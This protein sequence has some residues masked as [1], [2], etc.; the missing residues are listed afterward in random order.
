MFRLCGREQGVRLAV[1]MAAVCSFACDGPAPT[2]V[3]AATFSAASGHTALVERGRQ[4]FFNE[5]FGGNGRT[6]GTCHPAPTLVLT[7]ADI[8][9]LSPDDPFF[10]GAMDVD[11]QMAARGMIRYPLGGASLF[12]PQMTVF[13]GIPTIRNVRRT[14]PFTSDG[15]AA[16][17][18]EQAAE[19]ALLHLL[20]GAADRPGER[21]P[22]AEELDAIVAFEEAM[23][24]PATG[25]VGLDLLS[26][27]AREGRKLF[28][29]KASCTSCHVPPLLTDNQF[30]GIVARRPDE[31][32][33]DPGRCRIEPSLPDCAQGGAAFNTPQLRGVA[34]SPPFFHDNSLATLRAVV[35]FY[36]SQR[37]SNSP[38]AQRLGIAPL[39]L[40]EAEREALVAFL[41]TL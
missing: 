23:S 24:E 37:F 34:K 26:A 19:A 32:A 17:L 25:G 8:A 1:V 15:R 5:T 39:H 38:A 9:R 6:C 31:A 35:D 3:S 40:T 18:Q 21:V 14:A 11:P 22:T 12:S 2:D 27:R 4:L 33:N 30:H 28:F 13:R 29:G 36:N 10:A 20:D 41:E 16:T 7:P